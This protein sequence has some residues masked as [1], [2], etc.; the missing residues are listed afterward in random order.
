MPKS[1]SNCKEICKQLE[2]HESAVRYF[3]A[4]LKPE[5][6]ID[7]LLGAL[8]D[9]QGNLLRVKQ[10]E[11]SHGNQLAVLMEADNC[12]PSANILDHC[13]YFICQAG[14]DDN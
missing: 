7:I 10:C 4:N 1:C 11:K 6:A 9:Y 13:I 2:T 12:K 3:F 5:Q 14:K 8:A